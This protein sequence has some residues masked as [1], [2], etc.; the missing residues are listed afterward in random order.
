LINDLGM[1]QTW[2]VQPPLKRLVESM[3]VVDSVK[4]SGEEFHD[5]DF[6]IPAI[7][8][9]CSF[10]TSIETVPPAPYIKA[11]P[12]DRSTISKVGICWKGSSV[13]RNN[14]I[15][16]AGLENWTGVLN[17][18]FNFYSLQ[19]DG[20]EEALAYPQIKL[21]P[22]PVDW[23]DTTR[24]METLDLVISVDTATVHLAGAMGIPCW[25][26]LHCRPYF[27]YPITR[28]DCPWYPS[29]RLFKQTKEYDWKPVF[30]R[31][32]AELCE[33]FDRINETPDGNI[34]SETIQKL[35]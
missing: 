17:L 12:R 13:N 1:Q 9:P 15:R 23:L 4:S 22:P 5:Y 8:L 34:H 11:E 21:L 35:I 27:V 3:G 31:I 24:Q 6:H 10:G 29:V 18:P 32:T 14:G 19:V 26:A 25:C 30:E 7:S 28:E 33:A 16:S 20:A 2:V